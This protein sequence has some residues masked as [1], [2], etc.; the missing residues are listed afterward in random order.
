MKKQAWSIF[1]LVFSLGIISA[2]GEGEESAEPASAAPV[3]EEMNME[4]GEVTPLDSLTLTTVGGSAGGFWSM[5]GEGIGSL[6]GEEVPNLQ[7]SYETGSGVGNLVNVSRGEVPLGIA[8]NFEVMAGLNGEEPFNEKLENVPALLSL[9]DNSPVQVVISERFAKQ[10]DVN[11]I[12]DIKEKEVP[13]RAAVNQ[14]G[15]LSEAVNRTIFE[16]NGFTYKDIES[17]GG[18]IFYEPYRPGSELMKNNRADM[19][20]VPVFAPDSAFQELATSTDIRLLSFDE[21]TQQ[22]LK[23]R[24]GL[25]PGI[26]EAGTYQ[27][28]ENDISTSFA[29]AFLI[30]EPDMSVEEAYTITRAIVENIDKYRSLHKNIAEI[31]PEQMANVEPATLHPGAELYFKEIGVIE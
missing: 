31:T 10:Y 7:Y 28:Q 27:W 8:F 14:R 24:M 3:E 16:A 29:S 22:V 25:N 20:G 6:I 21:N 17:W 13:V 30:A 12:S 2:C 5:L 1:L 23:E 4:E 15:N 26:I 18:S 11:T 19:V 9:Y